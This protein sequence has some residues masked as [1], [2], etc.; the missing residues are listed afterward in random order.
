MVSFGLFLSVGETWFAGRDPESTF[1]GVKGLSLPLFTVLVTPGGW[2][3]VKPEV[4]KPP[5]DGWNE[6]LCREYSLESRVY[7]RMSIGPS[8]LPS[9]DPFRAFSA[10]RKPKVNDFGEPSRTCAESSVRQVPGK[11][12]FVKNE[13]GKPLELKAASTLTVARKSDDGVEG[14]ER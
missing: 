6:R 10:S 4:L 7:G 9:V 2:N 11:P 8:S 5:A 14:D 13:P 12:P 1:T 3:A